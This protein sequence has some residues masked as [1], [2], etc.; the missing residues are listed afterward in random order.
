MT[1]YEI[2]FDN[3]TIFKALLIIPATSLAYYCVNLMLNFIGSKDNK[4]I[5]YFKHSN[6]KKI[7]ENKTHKIISLIHETSRSD[8]LDLLDILQDNN[9]DYCEIKSLKDNFSFYLI[10]DTD[11]INSIRNYEPKCELFESQ[12]NQ[13]Y[14]VMDS[15]CNLK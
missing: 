8:V 3:N 13:P 5:Q 4:Q 10:N 9:S 12:L 6:N 2:S 7:E 11:L 14:L 1:S 15:K